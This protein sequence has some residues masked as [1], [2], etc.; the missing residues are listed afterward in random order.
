[1]TGAGY[2]LGTFSV[3]G[4]PAF[5]GLVV[6]GVV[7]DLRAEFGERATTLSLLEDWDASSAR[8]AELAAAGVA[9]GIAIERLRA[10]APVTSRQILCAGANNH[11]HVVEMAVGA[12]RARQ[13]ARPEQELV[14]AAR[15]EARDLREAEPFMFCVLPSSLCGAEDD[16]VLWEPGTRHDWEVELA[17]VIGRGGRDIP[18]GRAMEH[19]AG[20]TVANDV[21]ARDLVARP[22][23]PMSD[24]LRAKSRRTFLPT[25]PCIVPSSAIP[26]PV[27][28]RTTLKV[29]GDVMQD[30]TLDDLIHGIDRLIAYASTVAELYPGD[31]LLTGSPAG[32]AGAHGGRWLQPGDVMEAEIHGIGLLRNRCVA[33]PGQ[34]A[35]G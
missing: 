12:M 23:I 28:L 20:Y 27:A 31:L 5:P 11:T 25:G 22:P 9:D 8:L 3:D 21:T 10:H 18:V 1:V 6:D 4:A 13:D 19:V 32:N 15:Q 16:V 29:N 35:E 30:E 34:V 33:D 26:D 24:L 14:A 2:G 7:A 17:V